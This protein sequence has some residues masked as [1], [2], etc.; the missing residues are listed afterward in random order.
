MKIKYLVGLM[1]VVWLCA[2]WFAICFAQSTICI[3]IDKRDTTLI[4]SCPDG[5]TRT[6]NLGGI[7]DLYRQGD[8]IDVSNPSD[9][10]ARP[11]DGIRSPSAEGTRHTDDIRNLRR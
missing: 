5:S 1:A 3:V 10:S 6:V 7:A 8:Q 11:S 2:T 4:V 9:R